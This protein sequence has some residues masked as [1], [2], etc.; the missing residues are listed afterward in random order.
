MC[1]RN[2]GRWRS[3]SNETIASPAFVRGEWSGVS[4]RSY[5]DFVLARDDLDYCTVDTD[6][7]CGIILKN[8]SL[9]M[10]RTMVPPRDPILAAQ[11]F[12]VHNDDQSAFDFLS[13]NRTQLLRLV[14]ARDFV[15]G[16]N[17]RSRKNPLVFRDA[18]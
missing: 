9:E 6:F 2:S 17:G 4:Y 14:T 12:R 8:R 7:G 5:L 1:L 11:W 15:H 13:K 10:G 16:L 3:P 18:S